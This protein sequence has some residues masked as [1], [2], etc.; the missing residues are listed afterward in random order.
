MSLTRL[1]ARIHNY[2]LSA[3]SP[4]H[5]RGSWS[6]QRFG[7]LPKFTERIN[8]K[9]E[10]WTRGPALPSLLDESLC[11][12][13]TLR[14]SPNPSGCPRNPAPSLGFS[15]G[16]PPPT[17]K[18]TWAKVIPAPKSC[19]LRCL[20]SLPSEVYL[21]FSCSLNHSSASPSA[22][23]TSEFLRCPP[24]GRF[25]IRSCILALSPLGCQSVKSRL[26][27]GP[28][29]PGITCEHVVN[30]EPE[31][32]P[33]LL[34]RDLYFNKTLSHP[35]TIPTP[36]PKWPA[37]QWMLSS[38]DLDLEGALGPKE[39]WKQGSSP[40]AG[41][42]EKTVSSSVLKLDNDWP[43]FCVGEV[44]VHS[45]HLGSRHCLLRFHL[46]PPGRSLFLLLMNFFLIA[47]IIWNKLYMSW[48]N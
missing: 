6:S 23:L 7:N 3:L 36:T 17:R 18:D 2:L 37:A 45:G 41:V 20:H 21:R 40:G 35:P 26:L 1:R 33:V 34:N 10:I 16:F 29:H 32:Y 38:S 30:A 46:G 4:L 24:G 11:Y 27:N 15:L 44:Q 42:F 39:T 14:G 25:S 28:Q 48:E 31:S 43:S 9:D 5:I 19:R 47:K 12:G 22:L 8:G 13:A